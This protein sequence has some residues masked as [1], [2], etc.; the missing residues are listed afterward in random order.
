M[1]AV[2]SSLITRWASWSLG[3]WKYGLILG[4][5][6]LLLLIGFVSTIG[7]QTLDDTDQRLK[8]IVATQ[9]QKLILT[10]TMHAA[11]RERTV[12]L[13]KLIYLEDPFDRDAEI[14]R[15]QQMAVDFGVARR[16]LIDLRLSPFEAELVEEQGKRTRRALPLQE[17]V[18]E[19]S[20]AGQLA[21]AQA[22]LVQEAIPAQTAVLDVLAELDNHTRE[23]VE[24]AMQNASLA[25]DKA[26]RLI[27]F[28]SASALGVGLLV[29]L[30]V[31]Y[32]TMRAGIEKE[33][34]ATHDTLT[35]LPNRML[36]LDRLAQALAQARR[37]KTLIGVL[38]IDLDRFKVI[39][40]T[41]GH[42]A[43][44]ELIRAMAGRLRN[45]VRDTD[46]VAR[47]S[48]DEFIVLVQKASRTEH[49]L[50]VVEKIMDTLQ[51]PYAIA[52]REIFTTCSL[53]VSF[54]P[55]DG[56]QPHDLLKHADAAM[57]HAKEEGRNR[58]RLFDASMHEQASQRLELETDL[59][60]ALENDELELFYQPQ[61]DPESG[62]ILALEALLRW[63]HPHR[64]LLSPAHF[65]S[66][67][68]ETGLI[69]P[70]AERLLVQACR[71]CLAWQQAGHPDL[72]VSFNLSA[73]EF[74]HTDLLPR[75]QQ[76]LADAD[77][78]PRHL[79][80][81]LSEGILMDNVDLAVARMNEIKALGVG[82]SVDDFG[83]GY[84][85]LA[86]L[87]RFPVDENKIDR[88]F[89]TGIEADRQAAHYLQAIL[90]LSDSLSLRTVIEGVETREQLEII[91][92]MGSHIIQG[93]LISRPVPADEVPGLLARDWRSLI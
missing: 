65:L 88:Y 90:A 51:Q 42:A 17:R 81:E 1:R 72:V 10:K 80:L 19:L 6:T 69:L 49:V 18:I 79:H 46:V 27:T 55:H 84:S 16:Q 40:D 60:H 2:L 41:L 87:K 45:A 93:Y 22:I 56:H 77:L 4:F 43:G 25:N 39:N 89:V 3:H 47:L 64:G 7:L 48:G 63:R 9:L 21:Q 30:V 73:N 85:S 29:A 91:R 86:H 59:R 20:A 78:A 23:Q 32:L 57:Y 68:E 61:L 28:L 15:F 50:Q 67:L 53:G 71:H 83:T 76:A 13:A 58:F 74:W 37:D 5:S 70:A 12:I 14:L 24:T 33:H 44:D 62:R 35:G 34:L 26:R 8:A 36:L 54:Y 38:F 75:L 52:G 82:L 31:A 92:G 11:A 66:L